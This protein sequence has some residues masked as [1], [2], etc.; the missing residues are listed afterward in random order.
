LVVCFSIFQYT[1]CYLVCFAAFPN[2]P[3]MT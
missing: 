1:E 2:A 3:T